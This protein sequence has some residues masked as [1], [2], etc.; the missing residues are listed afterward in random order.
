VA[1]CPPVLLAARYIRQKAK[2]LGIL[3]RRIPLDTLHAAK[4][5]LLC[6]GSLHNS[7]RTQ[8]P[9]VV[10]GILGHAFITTAL[11]ASSFIYYQ[12]MSA[13]L[14]TVLARLRAS[15]PAQQAQ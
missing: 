2:C 14:Q 8:F 6:S 3:P 13:W 10:S 9:L 7:D 12:D 11:L 4:Q 1:D 15:M 5:Q